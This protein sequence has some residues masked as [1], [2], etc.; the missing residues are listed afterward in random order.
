M[1]TIS[2][3]SGLTIDQLLGAP[4]IYSSRWTDGTNDFDIAINKV[5]KEMDNIKKNWEN[6]NS[7]KFVCNMTLFWPDGKSF[8]SEGII[9]GKISAMKR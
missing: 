3:D 4:G 1:I 2:D 6:D 9:N 5:F 7:A 8:S